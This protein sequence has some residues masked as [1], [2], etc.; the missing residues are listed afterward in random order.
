M[1]KTA[2]AVLNS[3]AIMQL[4]LINTPNSFSETI[5]FMCMKRT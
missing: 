3:K 1:G 5:D 4:S 2:A